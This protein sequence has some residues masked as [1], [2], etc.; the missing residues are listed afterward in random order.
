MVKNEILL[1]LERNISEKQ[2]MEMLRYSDFIVDKTNK[3]ENKRFRI[4]CYD[5][6]TYFH[7]MC[8]GKVIECF[9]VAES[10]KPFDDVTVW[11]YTPDGI[12]RVEFDNRNIEKHC[13]LN[14]TIQDFEDGASF[15]DSGNT[16]ILDGGNVIVNGKKIKVK[17][18]FDFI[19]NLKNKSFIFARN[20]ASGLYS[21]LEHIAF[22]K[23]NTLYNYPLFYN[24][25][26]KIV[27]KYC[28]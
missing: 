1:N 7:Y 19:F 5:G 11:A 10:W 26:G 17:E 12:H 18:D 13:V 24:A 14:D 23:S 8:N 16:V 27:D 3:E 6:K 21:F 9:E 20:G 4:L 2:A 22:A 28:V 25:L 15:E